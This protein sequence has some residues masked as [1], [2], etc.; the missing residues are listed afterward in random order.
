[1]IADMRKLITMIAAVLVSLSLM[2]QEGGAATGRDKVFRIGADASADF[3]LAPDRLPNVSFGIGVRA[4]YGRPDQW[5]NVIGGL[6]YIYGARLSGPMIPLLLN[7]NLLRTESF[8]AYLGGGYEFDFI[9]TYWGCAKYQA[10]F[11]I[12]PHTDIQIS[13]KPYQGALGLG[14]TYYF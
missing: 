1:M 10:G 5:I 3:F 12:G 11:L 9:G 8:S 14:F 2:G 7:V 4:R 6:R 13:Y